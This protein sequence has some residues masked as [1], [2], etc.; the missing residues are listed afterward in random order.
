MDK[1]IVYSKPNC[2]NCVK[3]K[4]WLEGNDTPFEEINVMENE[5]ALNYVMNDLGFSGLPVTLVQ[6]QEPVA[7]FVPELLETYINK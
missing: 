2:I 5:V 3:V 4:N 1:V 7:G 6:G